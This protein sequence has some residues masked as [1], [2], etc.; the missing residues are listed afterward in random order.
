MKPS[1][2]VYIARTYGVSEKTVRDIWK[3]RTWSKETWHLDTA[4]IVSIKRPGRPKGCKDTRPRKT[5]SV[6]VSKIGHGFDHSTEATSN[7]NMV[8]FSMSLSMS[9]LSNPQSDMNAD[10]GTVLRCSGCTP[11]P[12]GPNENFS[13]QTEYPSYHLLGSCCRR[14]SIDSQL[15]EWAEQ[16]TVAPEFRDPFEGDVWR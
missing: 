11:E 2:A 13:N 4:R 1:T 5:R 9:G 14:I 3:G 6:R 15:F 12:E 16:A 7:E 10:Q 8:K